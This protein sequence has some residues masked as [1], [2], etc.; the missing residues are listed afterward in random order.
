MTFGVVDD[1]YTGWVVTNLQGWF[2]GPAV[3]AAFTP[4]TFAHGSFD[5]KVWRDVRT[6]TLSGTYSG[7]SY[8]D[9]VA[10][11]QVLSGLLGDGSAGTFM[12]DN[13][14]ATVRIGV[15]PVYQWL[16]DAAFNFQ[17]SF[18][19]VDPKKYGPTQ[20]VGPLNMAGVTSGGIPFPVVNGVF[21]WGTV[22]LPPSASLTNGGTADTPLLITVAAGGTALTGG[23]QILEA[24]TGSVLSYADDLPAGSSVVFD[25]GAGSVIL[26]GTANRRG[27]L[28]T[29][30]W[31]QI[32]AGTTRTISFTGLTGTSATATLTASTRP[33]YW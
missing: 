21:T 27:S 10:Q 23:F 3:R 25:T 2:D 18:I 17:V 26:N 12:V 5:A 24:V 15:E 6:V 19:A 11:S 29:A 16:G 33:A 30:Q 4:R 20:T 14:S 31:F 22:T 8:N 9:A 7:S 13:I 32:P 28:T 1:T